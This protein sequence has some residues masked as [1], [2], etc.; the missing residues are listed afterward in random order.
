MEDCIPGVWVL[1]ATVAVLFVLYLVSKLS[2][3]GRGTPPPGPRGWTGFKEIMKATLD[4]RLYE[5]AWTWAEKYG[6][7]TYYNVLGQKVCVLNS[8]EINRRLCRSEEYKMLTCD[9]MPNVVS[10]LAWYNGK[11]LF[12]TPYDSTMKQKRI[13]FFKLM[14]LY[15]EGVDK[16]ENVVGKELNRLLGELDKAKGQD[17]PIHQMLA[18][19]LKVI[20]FLLVNGDMNVEK[21]SYEVVDILERYD[22]ALNEMLDVQT[23]TALTNFPIL[24][25][26]GKFKKLC[27]EV[28]ASKVEAEKVLFDDIKETY[29]PGRIRGFA[30][31][32]LDFQSQPDHEWLDDEQIRGILAM[33]FF[34]AHMTSRGSL[35]NIILVLIHHQDVAKRIQE[36]IDTVLGDRRPQVHD[37]QNMHYTEAVILENLR[38]VSQL[39]LGNMR[40]A[41]DDIHID[42]YV[43]PKGTQFP[44]NTW[45]FHRDPKIWDDPWTFQPE[46]FLDAKGIILPATHPVRKQLQS[47][48]IGVRMCPGENFA[49]S[50]IFLFVVSILQKYDVLPPKN[51]PLVSCDPRLNL[52]GV[53]RQAP[54]YKCTLRDRIR[55]QSSE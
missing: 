39:A 23:L 22:N 31:A 24:R 28:R 8:A 34:A 2:G 41:R 12:F 20:L 11:E 1:A 35:L 5:A 4:D 52:K 18:R 7:M 54:P 33:T 36:E 9:R 3:F 46:R 13:L 50:R 40:V 16:F 27:D 26:F 53:I 6:D 55:E 44:V 43:I 15:G 38:Y 47:F 14:G 10:E 51:E 29:V 45:F 19:S 42:G 30:D 37:R 48:G 49:R 25:R 21:V 17:V 32:L